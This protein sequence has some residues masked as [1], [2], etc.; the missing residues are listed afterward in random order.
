[1]N[2]KAIVPE[3]G[4]GATVGSGSDCYP[5]T[6]IEVNKGKDGVVTSFAIQWD[7][8][9]NVGGEWPHS[10]KYEYEPNPEG[11][12]TYY[13]LRKTGRY[14]QKG[15]ALRSPG[16]GIGIGHRRYYQDPSF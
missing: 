14:K 16:G 5:A 12:I 1:V 9:K 8:A 15:W 4:M 3:V 6:I 2:K 7:T 10:L 11:T 13:T